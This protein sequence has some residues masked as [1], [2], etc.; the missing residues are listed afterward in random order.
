M[1]KREKLRDRLRNNLNNATFAMSEPARVMPTYP[2]VLYPCDRSGYVAE[3]PA[4]PGC[5]APGETLLAT[6]SELETVTALWI[7]TAR[8][9]GQNLPDVE[10]AIAKVKTLSA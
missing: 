7:E 8:N 4:L 3:I 2:I 1:S 6:L 9:R 5:L 10:S